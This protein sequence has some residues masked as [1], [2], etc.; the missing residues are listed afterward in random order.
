MK[1]YPDK[2]VSFT[3]YADDLKALRGLRLA[4]RDLGADVELTDAMR[5]LIYTASEAEMFSHAALRLQREEKSPGRSAAT[6]ETR[7]SVT[8]PQAFIDKLGRVRDDLARKDIEAERTFIIR[9][10]LHAPPD[11]KALRKALPR[12]EQE[13]PDKRSLRPKRRG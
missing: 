11:A 2:R 10:L 13:F 1:S 6:V 7:F 8:L 4:L 12:L 9:A 5:V 3:F